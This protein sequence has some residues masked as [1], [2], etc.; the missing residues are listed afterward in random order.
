MWYEQFISDYYNRR[1]VC[2]RHVKKGRGPIKTAC[3]YGPECHAILLQQ[4][5]LYTP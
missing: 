5:T 4:R 2:E 3:V 1:F